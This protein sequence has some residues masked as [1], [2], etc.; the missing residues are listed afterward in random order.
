MTARR[1][2]TTAWHAIYPMKLLIAT[3]NR[4]K[5]Q[6]ISA[7]LKVP[8]LQ[9]LGLADIAGAPGVEED[10]DT[11]EFN[12]V[13]KA[14][15]LARFAG[16]WTLADD[17][18]LE[19]QAL[20]GAPGVW[21]ARFAG[22]PGNDAANNAKLLAAMQG[23]ANRRAQFRCVIALSDPSGTS[24]T[25][26]GACP[27]ALL[28]AP[29]GHAGFGYDPLFVP[30]GYDLTF[31]ELDAA[32]KNRISHRAIALATALAEWGDFLAGEPAAWGG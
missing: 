19:V 26:T 10:G 8:H 9:L 20:D 24:R 4:H 28:G 5:L 12:A 6:E 31:A 14:S 30:D 21:S 18:G 23:V 22:L 17:S 25:V 11:F 32:T 27:G 15:I 29:R 2:E 1:C 13:K 16:C 3:G 7:I